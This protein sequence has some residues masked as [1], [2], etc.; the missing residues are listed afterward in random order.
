MGK[1]PTGKRK[2]QIQTVWAQHNEIARRL[3]LGEKHVDIARDMG[4]TTAM[5]SYTANS[6]LVQQEMARLMAARDGITVDIAND[7]QD[8]APLALS[9]VVKAMMNSEATPSDV[10]RIGFGLLDRAGFGPVKKELR[11]NGTLTREDVKDLNKRGVS[12]MK[13]LKIKRAEPTEIEPN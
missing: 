6:H 4:I 12:L 9:E 8:L 10:G 2:Y 13:E 1:T 7:I 3:V 5:V 11:V